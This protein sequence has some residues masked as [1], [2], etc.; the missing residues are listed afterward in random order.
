MAANVCVMH[1]YECGLAQAGWVCVCEWRREHSFDGNNIHPE[2]AETGHKSFIL[3]AYEH[4]HFDETE[5][6]VNIRYKFENQHFGAKISVH[7]VEIYSL[8]FI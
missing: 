1:M 2:V 4:S 6:D 3:I 7:L 8:R 5:Y